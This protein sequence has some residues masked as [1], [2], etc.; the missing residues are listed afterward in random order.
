[1]NRNTL[2]AAVCRDEQ[3]RLFAEHERGATFQEMHRHDRR[4]G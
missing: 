2:L 3:Q 4:A 1:M